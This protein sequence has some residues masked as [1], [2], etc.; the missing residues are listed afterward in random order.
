MKN[1]ANTAYF[2]QWLEQ[3]PN[4]QFTIICAIEKLGTWHG[5][6]QTGEMFALFACKKF[7]T[8]Y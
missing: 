3:N 8:S 5:E 7:K 6:A 4:T 1:L 2:I